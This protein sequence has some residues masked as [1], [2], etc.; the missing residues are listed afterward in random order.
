MRMRTLNVGKVLFAAA[1][2]AS[3]QSGDDPRDVD[4]D[5]APEAVAPG[6]P[7]AAVAA[8]LEHVIMTTEV[9]A[10]ALRERLELALQPS[11]DR[12]VGGFVT[13]AVANRGGRIEFTPVGAGASAGKAADDLTLETIAIRRGDYIIDATAGGTTR[14]ADGAIETV[15]S[16]VVERLTNSARGIEQSWLFAEEPGTEGDLEVVVDVGTSGLLAVTS[17]GLHFGAPG[18]LGSRYSHATWVDANGNEAEVPARF[19][20]G[21]IRLVVSHDVLANAAYPAVL[22]PTVTAEAAVDAPVTGGTNAASRTPSVAIAGG[23]TLA[24]WADDRDEGTLANIYA[25]RV[26]SAGAVLD[27]TAIQLDTT[28]G[29][30]AA[31]VVASLGSS[32]LAVWE[33]GSGGLKG[34]TIS[35]AGAVTSLGTIAATGSE[36]TLAARGSE[37]LLAYRT[38]DDIAAKIFSGGAFGGAIAVA[39]TAAVEQQPAA[40][41]DPAGNYLVTWSDGAA[42][43]DLKGQLVTPAGALSGAAITVSA[44]LGTQSEASA[45]FAGGNFVVLWTNNRAGIDIYGTRVST[46]GVVLDTR[47]EGAATVGG[48]GIVTAAENQNLGEVACASGGCV[49]TWKD[50]RNL[51]TNGNDVYGLAITTALAPSGSEFVVGGATNEQGQPALATDGTDYFAAW[52]DQ[53]SNGAYQIYGSRIS[54]AGAVLDASGI[55]LSLGNN[56]EKAPAVVNGSSTWFTAWS[57]SRDPAGADIVGVR[58]NNNG[59]LL[60]ASAKTISNAAKQ[61]QTPRLAASSTAFLA[62][63]SDGRGA[64]FDIYARRVDPATG[65]TLGT[66]TA[67]TTATADQFLPAVASNGTTFLVVWQDKRTAANNFDIYGALVAADGTVSVA[68]IAIYAGAGEQ[69]SPAVA[70]DPTAGQYVVVWSDARGGAGTNDIYGTRVS[71]AGAVLDAGGVTISAGAASQLAPA[72]ATGASGQL[73]VAWDDRRNANGDIFVGRITAGA[74]L[75]RLDADGVAFAVV[76]GSK[77]TSPAATYI[78]SSYIVVWTDERALATN[79]R[80]LYGKAM[81]TVGVQGSEFAVSV[82]TNDEA[83]PTL[84]P[85]PTASGTSYGLLAYDRFEPALDARRVFYRRVKAD[86]AGGGTCSTNAQCESGFCV[87]GKCCDQACGGNSQT[88]CQ[89]CSKARGAAVD[90]TCAPVQAGRICRNYADN[91]CDLRE[92]CD[93]AQ[94]TCPDDVGRRQGNSCNI[95]GGGTG[96]CPPN[97][98]AGAPH[99][100]Q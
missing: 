80:D 35:S 87:D 23:Q 55:F 86:G 53:R 67:V 24:V 38:G 4:P 25:A 47:L 51:A 88:D 40:A 66:E 5:S 31:P 71:A 27:S 79:G 48:I 62:V 81:S 6:E 3:C 74:S 82:T 28:A 58:V 94:I 46:A 10:S 12:F 57:D 52:Q 85:P 65:N 14:S 26:S 17:T 98:V 61:Q 36:P 45:S 39:A 41:A 43:L 73:L 75:T 83:N 97:A 84:T 44:A 96:T 15:R 64:D 100:C 56:A 18:K 60:D 72:I 68:D 33:N 90:G 32:Y 2:V 29:V 76:A 70:W 89:A 92:V 95:A 93:G 69:N 11:G 20:N 19:E 54:G 49:L 30:Q 78:G 16:E 50:R 59:N 77:Q 37:V 21:Q 9:D 99:V 13:H 22:D 63:W 1:L 8:P 91:Y 42:S 34:A 7:G